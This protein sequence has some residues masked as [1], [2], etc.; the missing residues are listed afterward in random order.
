MKGWFLLLLGRV[1]LLFLIDVGPVFPLISRGRE[2]VPLYRAG[3][4]GI[5][6]LRLQ[7]GILVLYRGDWVFFS[8]GSRS[9]FGGVGG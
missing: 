1:G 3:L 6:V 4:G 8:C 9:C 2:G 5:W 7:G